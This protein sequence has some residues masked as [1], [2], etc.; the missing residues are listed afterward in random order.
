MIARYGPRVAVSCGVVMAG[1]QSFSEGRVL[2]VSSPGCLIECV[3]TLRIGD[4]VQL[5]VFLPDQD[6]PLNIPLAAV[7]WVDST[8][9]GLEFIKSSE[10]DQLRLSRFVRRHAPVT[11]TTLKKWK[12]GV[13]LLGA[14]GD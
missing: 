7:R 13:T 10:E 11:V 5:R 4:Y 2:D 14:S 8:R 3:H 6:S 12:D 9:V 1:T